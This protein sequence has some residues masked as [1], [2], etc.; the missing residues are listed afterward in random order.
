MKHT[1]KTNHAAVAY[2]LIG[3]SAA[4]QALLSAPAA[5]APMEQ[6]SLLA[7]TLVGCLLLVRR[8]VAALVCCCAQLGVLLV[9]CGTA[10]QASAWEM[11]LYA[12]NH[13]LALG[14]AYLLLRT[15]GSYPRAMPLL[16]AGALAVYTA[17][18]LAHGPGRVYG[19]AFVVYAVA[20]LWF[21]VLM[22]RAYRAENSKASL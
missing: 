14:T 9:L 3:V 1:S 15:A 21:A 19:L 4:G 12:L 20:M 2:L 10:V 22:L 6:L 18:L 16:A 7:L 11:P 17:V 13:W 5:P 8:S